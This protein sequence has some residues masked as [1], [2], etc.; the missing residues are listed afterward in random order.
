MKSLKLITIK[1]LVGGSSL[2]WW[3]LEC[4]ENGLLIK[5]EKNNENIQYLR[6]IRKLTN[7]MKPSLNC[8]FKETQ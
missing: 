6:K 4:F 7:I 5:F 3:T 2:Y 8:S 1:H